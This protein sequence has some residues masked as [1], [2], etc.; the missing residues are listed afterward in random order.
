MRHE[1]QKKLE[2]RA[3]RKYVQAVLAAG[4]K[5][6]VFDGEEFFP[7]TDKI[8]EILENMFAVDECELVLHNSV[9]AS[10]TGKAWMRFIFGNAPWEVLNDYSVSLEP[11]VGPVNEYVFGLLYKMWITHH[12]FDGSFRILGEQEERYGR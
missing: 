4:F 5:I 10:Y 12:T 2:R 8:T 7:K 11:I 3:V 6:E 1:I 9:H